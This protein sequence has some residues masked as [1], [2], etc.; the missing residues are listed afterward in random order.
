M[1]AIAAI[2][3]VALWLGRPAGEPHHTPAIERATRSPVALGA[4]L[5][6][7]YGCVACHTLDGAPRVGPTF[8]HDFGTAIT[9]E[10]GITIRM[11]EAY[12]RESLMHPQA[13]ARPGYPPSMPSYEGILKER[14]IRA[15]T[16]FIRSLK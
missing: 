6:E 11:D 10:G 2:T 7:R 1:A 12:I 4:Q 5:Y 16:A 9:L 14:E 8:L 15:L 3:T 13:Q